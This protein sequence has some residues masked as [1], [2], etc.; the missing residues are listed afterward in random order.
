[1]D[2]AL[3]SANINQ[4][5]YLLEYKDNQP[6]FATSFTLVVTSLFLQIAVSLTLIW[7]I[8][9]AETKEIRTFEGSNNY[10]YPCP[11]RFNVK[12]RNEMEEADRVN[13]IGVIGIF[14]VTIINVALSTFGGAP[15]PKEILV[16]SG[17]HT[18]GFDG[19]GG[20]TLEGSGD[21]LFTHEPTVYT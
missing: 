2:L 3:L 21:G 8:R 19:I 7:N 17:G 12:K 6:Y 1:M 4:M 5:R 16:S 13:N 11:N 10:N 20:T 9:F 15:A 14:L 18:T